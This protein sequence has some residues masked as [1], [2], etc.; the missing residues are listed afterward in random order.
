MSVDWGNAALDGLYWSS[1]AIMFAA[2]VGVALPQLLR[3]VRTRDADGVSVPALLFENVA[4]IAWLVYYL[5][6]RAWT[7]AI[8]DAAGLLVVAMLTVACAR[9]GASF[10][11][12]WFIATAC[13]AGL[14]FAAAAGPQW[15]EWAL[16]LM[17]T[18]T[19][20]A[21]TWEAWSAESISG[22]SVPTWVLG[23]LSG[24]AALVLGYGFDAPTGLLLAGYTYL[25][26]GL[27]VLAAVYLRPEARRPSTVL[28][29]PDSTMG[30]DDFPAAV[31]A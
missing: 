18:M 28:S 1:T 5:A 21:Y 4:Y 16:V 30:H 20:S 29:V 31:P 13:A 6:E 9:V 7:L 11:D 24:V 2:F 14:A 19:L 12:G 17:S 27:A 3:T 8:A 22:I 26:S 25:F 23:A 10:R 15:F